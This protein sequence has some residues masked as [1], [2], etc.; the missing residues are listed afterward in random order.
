MKLFKGS[1][2]S[3]DAASIVFWPNLAIVNG[4]TDVFHNTTYK[5]CFTCFKVDYKNDETIIE[6]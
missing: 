1:Y 4:T 6:I 2:L 3:V 5:F